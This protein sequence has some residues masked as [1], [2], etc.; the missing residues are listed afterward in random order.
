MTLRFTLHTARLS[1]RGL[2]FS[3]CI[4]ALSDPR[5]QLSLRFL[6]VRYGFI[7]ESRRA[8][9]T[10]HLGQ[11]TGPTKSGASG[12]GTLSGN[13]VI[14]TAKGG[15]ESL[16]DKNT[17]VIGGRPCV[18]WPISA[19]LGAKHV[20]HVFVSTEDDKIREVADD[21]GAS[22]IDRPV[23][24]AQP[25]TNHGDVIFHAIEEAVRRNGIPETLTILLGNTVMVKASDIDATIERTL[26]DKDTDGAMTVWI[27]Q[28]DHPYRALI[29]DESGYLKP[30]LSDIRP[31]TNRQSYPSVV[32]YDQGPWTVRYE[33][34]IRSQTTREGPGPWWWM[35]KN[36]ASIERP[37]IT[38]RDTHTPLDLA[39]AEWWLSNY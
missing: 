39:I 12:E 13:I 3:I 16:K 23:E 35:G 26:A 18:A 38:G 34:L 20:S 17:L 28:D 15:N 5:G 33:S 6:K 29:V 8:A 25:R 10:T 2:Q 21:W 24:L 36:C 1:H 11:R 4:T 14:I 9:L 19:A 31:D 30:F 32:Y 22:V 37:W 7:A 27:A